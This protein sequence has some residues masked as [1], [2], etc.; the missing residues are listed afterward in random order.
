MRFLPHN[1]NPFYKIK[2]TLINLKAGGKDQIKK[3]WR[4]LTDYIKLE[5]KF[6]N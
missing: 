2:E 6:S 1:Q 5:V 3:T 4:D